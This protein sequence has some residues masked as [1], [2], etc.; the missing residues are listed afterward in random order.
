MMLQLMSMLPLLFRCCLYAASHTTPPCSQ[1]HAEGCRY[2]IF[3]A[4][5]DAVMFR[6]FDR[7]FLFAAER[8]ADAFDAAAVFAVFRYR[9]RFRR[10]VIEAADFSP[11][12]ALF[13]SC[14]LLSLC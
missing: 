3:F 11:A 1:R 14:R 5:V 10:D 13:T 12:P 6:H 4:A 2:V 9:H 8:H 7:C